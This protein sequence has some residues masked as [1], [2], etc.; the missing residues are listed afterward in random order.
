MY[1]YVCVCM[2]LCVHGWMDGWMDGYVCMHV[3]T[4]VCM[5]VCMHTCT[6]MLACKLLHKEASTR[7]Y[8]RKL[9]YVAAIR[10]F[11]VSRLRV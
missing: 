2:Y 11:A 10:M 1:T 6:V 4:Y 3:R 7:P 9:G 8:R 5:Y